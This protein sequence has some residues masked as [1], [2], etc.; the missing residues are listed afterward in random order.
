MSIGRNAALLVGA[1]LLITAIAHAPAARADVEQIQQAAAKAASLTR[2]LLTFSRKQVIEPTLVD[3]NV[4]TSGM[5]TMLSRLI[6]EDV[7]IEIGR[8]H[9]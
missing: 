3:L 8:A 2:Q 7:R 9:V 6:G 1:G 4:V 5:R